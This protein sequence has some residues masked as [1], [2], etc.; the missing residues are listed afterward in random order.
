MEKREL[1]VI[2]ASFIMASTVL[3][4]CG[5]QETAEKPK[6]Q[7][8]EQT[9]TADKAEEK[10]EEVDF[11]AVYKEA[12]TELDKA[13]EQKEVDFAMVTDLYTK[14]LQ[15][16]VQKRD[17]E[18][19]AQHDQH[20]TAALKA[21]Q[22]GSM[23]PIV[24]RQIFDKL[25]QK[26][27]Y[28]TVKH[29]FT[30]VVEN[31]DKKDIV[32][33]EIEEAKEYYAILKST[34]EKRDAAYGTNMVSVIDGGFAEMEK[35]VEGDDQL[36]FQLGKQVVD[37]TL[38]KTFYFATGAIPNGYATKAAAEAKENPEVAK[39]EQAEGWAFYQSL[40]SYLN[41]HSPEEAAFIES[42]FNL[43][44]DVAS[45]DP[46]AVNKAFVRGFSKIALDEYAESVEAWGEDKS[47]ITALEGALFIDVVGEDIK[48]IIGAEAYQT[49]TE[50]ARKY[51]ETAKAKDKV[52]GEP[53]LAEIQTTLQKVIEQAK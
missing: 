42:Q 40:I 4:A 20:I 9:E 35:A 44:T 15:S 36:G 47:P 7:K 31:W 41:S 24:V 32:K 51:L 29:E 33:E 21:G 1:K 17:A 8:Q 10:T 53:V 5:A 14:N 38:M 16:L 11:A 50:Q 43:E 52:A 37:K 13:K 26:V 48:G 25:M 28:T 23:D 2:F 39:I 49:L 27:F 18:V 46:A 3:G 6:E 30:E 45:L 22:D 34:V 12:I 19:E